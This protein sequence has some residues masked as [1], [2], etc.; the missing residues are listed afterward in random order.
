MSS[1]RPMFRICTL[2]LRHIAAES[3]RNDCQPKDVEF[4]EITRDM[5]D[6]TIVDSPPMGIVT[7]SLLLA[8]KVDYVLLIIKQGITSK[9]VISELNQMLGRTRARIIG[10]VLN[11]VKIGPGY[12]HYYKYYYHR[13]YYSEST[14]KK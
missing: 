11:N 6:L 12:G 3:G 2:F 8:T 10:A 7:D 4:F 1:I 13:Y 9:N 14:N 5:F